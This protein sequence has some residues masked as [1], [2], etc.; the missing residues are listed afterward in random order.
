MDVFVY[1]LCP[2]LG[3]SV[4]LEVVR[5]FK[6][7]KKSVDAVGFMI[8]GLSMMVQLGTRIFSTWP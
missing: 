8:W 4:I 3:I 5:S 6:S 1:T 2:F 7:V